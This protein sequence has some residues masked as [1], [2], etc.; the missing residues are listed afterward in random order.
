M[1]VLVEGESRK[2]A[3]SRLKGRSRTN[4]VVNFEGDLSLIGKTV[5]VRITGAGPWSL[6]GRLE[7]T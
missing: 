3:R 4:K 5:E 2:P 7:R 1:E 6:A